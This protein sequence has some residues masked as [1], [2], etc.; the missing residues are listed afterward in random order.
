M[1]DDGNVT[2]HIWLSMQFLHAEKPPYQVLLEKNFNTM[3]VDAI[4]ELDGKT[5]RPVLV[6]L[7]ADSNFNELDSITSSV[8]MELADLLRGKGIM[9]TT[10]QRIWRSMYSVY[11][12]QFRIFSTQRSGQNYGKTAIWAVMEKHLFRQRVFLMCATNRERVSTLNHL[13][14]SGLIVLVLAGVA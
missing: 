11:G 12:R 7:S 9:V 8:A 14:S 3:F 1:N 6:T 13:R 5:T 4:V 2:V 10:D